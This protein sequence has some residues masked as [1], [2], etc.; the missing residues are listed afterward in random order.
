M[1]HPPTP[2]EGVYDI[3]WR[4]ASE[5]QAAFERRVAGAPGPWTDD[6]ILRA[7]KFCNVYRASDRVSQYLI[8]NIAYEPDPSSPEDRLFEILAF[9][10]FSRIETWD[11]LR[12]VLG[13][14]PGLRELADGS[15]S[16]ALDAVRERN[17]GLYT[18]AFILCAT[19]A[20]SQP[21]KHRN[22]VE[23]L[24]HMFLMEGLGQ[25]LLESASLAE[26]FT[27]LR[28]FPLIGDF[29]A[30]QTAVDLNYS[31][32]INF[33][34]NDFTKPGPGALRGLRKAFSDLGSLSPQEAIM[35]MVDN[36]QTEFDRLG[37]KFGGLW[38][39][40][41]HAIDCQGLF[42]EMDKYCRE[43]VP[44]LASNRSRIKARF[45]PS[46]KPLPLFFPPKWGINRLLPEV[47]TANPSSPEPAQSLLAF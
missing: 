41:L 44:E 1:I 18:G 46:A 2:R 21:N 23:L 28:G 37:L 26:V 34:E 43:A 24:K 25:R 35:Y 45:S 36:Q 10:L 11:T 22:H 19:D 9:R 14:A 38:G 30:Y 33:D 13:G 20:Y 6:P 39:R 31:A 40:P 29:M 27:L 8:R 42:C 7:F 17:G 15:F 5:R 12:S 3:Y 47:A 32:F 4:F 16:A